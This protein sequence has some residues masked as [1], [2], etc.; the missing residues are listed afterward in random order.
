MGKMEEVHYHFQ[1]AEA[2]AFR[3]YIFMGDEDVK[4][5]VPPTAVIALTRAYRTKDGTWIVGWSCSLEDACHAYV[6]VYAKKK[7]KKEEVNRG[8]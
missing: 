2:R 8:V 1:P 3:C 5:S 7:L 4:L 6:C